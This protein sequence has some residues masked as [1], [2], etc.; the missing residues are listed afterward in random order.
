MSAGELLGERYALGRRLG[1]GGFATVY[2]ATDQRFGRLVAVKVLD[3]ALALDPNFLESFDREARAVAALDHPHILTVHDYG[4]HQGTAFLVMPF[5]DGGSLHERIARTGPLTP[6][7]AATYLRQ[8]AAALDYAHACGLIHRDIKPHN[9]LLRGIGDQRLLLTDFG[10]AAARE[11]AD[12]TGASRAIGT[13]AYM[14]PERF[15]GKANVASDVYALGCTLWELLTGLPPYTGTTQEVLRSQI[16]APIPN[17]AER[18]PGLPSAIQTVLNR[19]LAKNPT[20]RFP[21]TGALAIAYEEA[22]GL[23]GSAVGQTTPEPHARP[24]LAEVAPALPITAHAEITPPSIGQGISKQSWSPRGWR[25]VAAIVLALSI[26]LALG[27]GIVA[28]G[29]VQGRTAAGAGDTRMAAAILT[30][31]TTLTPTVT[32]TVTPANT[33]TNTPTST[34]V[35]T[36]TPDIR[37][38]QTRAAELAILATLAA[39][40][41]TPTTAPTPLPTATIPATATSAPVA[42]ATALPPTNTP[43]PLPTATIIPAQV[44][45]TEAPSGELIYASNKEGHWAIYRL[46]ANGSGERRLTALTADNYSGVWSPDGAQIA[47]ISERDGNP[48]VYL[49]AADGSGAQRLTTS[50]EEESA[51]AW[52]PDGRAIAFISGQGEGASISLLTLANQRSVRLVNSPAGWPTW[53]RNGTLVFVRPVNGI[54]TLHA[55]TADSPNVWVLAGANGIHA[56]T[57]AFAPDGAR[58]AF[59]S[60]PTSN[61]RQLIIANADGSNRRML[62]TG[63]ADTS[64][65]TWS[66]DGSWLAFASDGSGSQQIYAIRADGTG[67]RALTS[68][69]GKKWY[70]SWRP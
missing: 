49:M 55:T 42:T 56:D 61:N 68:G 12:A 11:T 37:P 48:E 69:A 9:L 63:G 2:L 14:A 35:V 47:F 24:T 8:A 33:P 52:S 25:A 65:P 3:P 27:S 19:A 41:A 30:P 32:S 26:V 57:P 10:I 21:T 64:D 46:S 62:T 40:T 50:R 51:P 13:V 28:A 23:T 60:G 44:R 67:L 45:T 59:A 4:T 38:T 66:P 36:A 34:P 5:V 31:S 16:L 20:E 6:T 70:L 39:P 29:R 53:S 1:R 22:I 17:L 58:L 15:D 18:R 54:L 7:E 43:R